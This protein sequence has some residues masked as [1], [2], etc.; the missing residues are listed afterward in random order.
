VCCPAV[1]A[2]ARAH[3]VCFSEACS[4]SSQPAHAFRLRL[5]FPPCHTTCGAGDQ[6]LASVAGKAG[7]LLLVVGWLRWVYGNNRTLE[8]ADQALI[9]H[10]S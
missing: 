7:W 10:E 8:V 6:G 4:C 5:G 3:G 1:P 2:A 9:T